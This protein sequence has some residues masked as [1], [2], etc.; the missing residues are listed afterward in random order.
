MDDLG[1]IRAHRLPPASAEVE[2]QAVIAWRCAACGE[3]VFEGRPETPC[4][5]A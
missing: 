4:T 5:V 1:E 3:W 2:W